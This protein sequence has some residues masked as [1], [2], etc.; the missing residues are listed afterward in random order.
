MRSY[1]TSILAEHNVN[2]TT[3]AVSIR[4]IPNTLSTKFALEIGD[5]HIY[6]VHEGDYTIYSV[7]EYEICSS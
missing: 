1:C 7:A 5:F 6:A 4:V 3:Y 2:R